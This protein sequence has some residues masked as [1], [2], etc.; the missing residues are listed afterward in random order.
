MTN[1]LIYLQLI[2]RFFTLIPI[3]DCSGALKMEKYKDLSLEEKEL[4][5]L[6]SRLPRIVDLFITRFVSMPISPFFNVS[7]SFPVM[8]RCYLSLFLTVT[9][10][11]NI[12]RFLS[13]IFLDAG[14]LTN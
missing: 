14:R 9:N 8:F 11:V 7:F 6:T 12:Y 5:K 13:V 10:F 3:I 4:C 1:F 2:T